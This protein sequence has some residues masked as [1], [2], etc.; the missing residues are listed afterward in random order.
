MPP[1]TRP[2]LFVLIAEESLVNLLAIGRKSFLA[3]LG[4]VIGTASVIA[5]LNIGHN[6]SVEALRQFRS[7][8]TDLLLVRAV[9]GANGTSVPIHLS[10]IEHLR[11][12]LSALTTTAPIVIGATRLGRDGN[13][14]ATVIGADS[15]LTE[16]A[17]LS[18]V[19]GR[20]ISTLD[21]H[22]TYAVIGS[23]IAGAA[24]LQHR[25]LR[26]GD[27]IKIENY[28]FT[29]VGILGEVAP[30]LLLPFNP[31]DT[32]VIPI[33][34][35]RRVVPDYGIYTF[36][37]CVAAEFD[38]IKI[39]ED[40]SRFF[41]GTRHDSGV[42]V[43]SAQQLIESM[44]QQARLYTVLL[45]GVGGISLIVGGV[46]VMNVMLMGVA[47]RR[48]EIGLRMALGARAGHIRAMFLIESSLL[49]ITGGLIGIVLGIA[50][51]YAYAR[52]SGWSFDLAIASL[53]FGVLLACGIGIFFGFFPAAK[54]ASLDPIS[55]LRAE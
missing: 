6:A 11:A 25:R 23:K 31:D 40:I 34:A 3:L 19:E 10:E 35:M 4:V 2:R 20:P 43:Q 13:I 39:G 52:F 36:L 48:K 15:K 18:V 28:R 33:A 49:C 24:G 29:V 8:G 27:P 30:N 54:A 16:A 22:G 50:T 51:S 9:P 42:V 38:P 12:S 1:L 7:L 37:A 5:M 53:P 44:T 26:V 21:E 46:G 55:A 41:Q 17:R 47:E 14:Q 32:I 45:A